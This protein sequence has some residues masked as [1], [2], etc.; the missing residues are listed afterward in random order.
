[1]QNGGIME[2]YYQ[3]LA[4]HPNVPPSCEEVQDV[5]QKACSLEL[6][7]VQ[8][9]PSFSERTTASTLYPSPLPLANS[10]QSL[11]TVSFSITNVWQWWGWKPVLFVLGAAASMIIYRHYRPRGRKVYQEI[12]DHQEMK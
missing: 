10:L 2:A 9:M 11:T 4:E 1:M 3:R 6:Y 5:L 12:P 8:D 7:N